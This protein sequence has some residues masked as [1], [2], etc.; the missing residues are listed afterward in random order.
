MY[1]IRVGELSVS[2]SIS[3][4]RV[5][6][7]TS[8]SKPR[9]FRRNEVRVEPIVVHDKAETHAATPVVETFAHKQHDL[10]ELMPVRR[11]FAHCNLKAR[12]CTAYR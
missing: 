7:K 6:R 5:G 12:R 3:I 1:E 4:K 11:N 10:K 2:L 8:M 9:H